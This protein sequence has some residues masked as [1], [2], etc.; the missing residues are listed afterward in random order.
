[1]V[2]IFPALNV[3]IVQWISSSNA[4]KKHSLHKGS[5]V[6]GRFKQ[7]LRV[8]HFVHN[9]IFESPQAQLLVLF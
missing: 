9:F 4:S 3:V 6:F 5:P 7:A 1:M 8:E 2:Y